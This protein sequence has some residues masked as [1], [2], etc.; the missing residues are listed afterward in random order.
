[1]KKK[2]KEFPK[3]KAVIENKCDQLSFLFESGVE[4][5]NADF[6][7]TA[8]K[9]N[10]GFNITK[11]YII[12]MRRFILILT[13]EGLTKSYPGCNW[14]DYCKTLEYQNLKSTARQDLSKAEMKFDFVY[15][16]C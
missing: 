11:Y 15:G 16:E 9:M 2:N 10:L 13:P 3:E 12:L 4:F 5:I 14:K 7:N 6:L 8:E 1:M